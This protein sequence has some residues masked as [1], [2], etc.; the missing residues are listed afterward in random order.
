A[1]EPVAYAETLAAAVALAEGRYGARPERWVHEEMV[2]D[3]YLDYRRAR[4]PAPAE[5]QPQQSEN[6]FLTW[7]LGVQAM[8]SDLAA[9][10]HELVRFVTRR[11]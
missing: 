6:P 7:R 5:R 8:A 3:E 1:D 4:T 2:G 9:L 10:L 11:S